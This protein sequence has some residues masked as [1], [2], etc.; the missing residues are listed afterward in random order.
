MSGIFLAV[1]RRSLVKP[2]LMILAF[3]GA[4]TVRMVWDQ[5]NPAFRTAQ[6][7]MLF[8]FGGTLIPI[9]AV[10]TMTDYW[11]EKKVATVIVITAGIAGF[12]VLYLRLSGSAAATELTELTGRLML[13]NLNPISMGQ[14]GVSMILAGPFLWR[15]ASL[16]VKAGLVGL[17]GLGAWLMVAANSRSPFLSLLAAFLVYLFAT[18][19]WRMLFILIVAAAA[20]FL[21]GHVMDQL[22]GSRLATIE[23]SSAMERYYVQNAAWS[24]FLEHPFLGAGYLD[25][26][27]G[28]Y[29]HNAMLESFMAL[30]FVGGALF[31]TIII[32]AVFH[33]LGAIRRGD[34]LL[35]ML[36]WQHLVL[37]SV[38]GSLYAS[39]VL[40]ALMALMSARHATSERRTGRKQAV[41]YQETLAYSYGSS[42]A[43]RPPPADDS[44]ELAL[45]GPYDGSVAQDD[46][47]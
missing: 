12:L 8:Y 11:R 1:V 29:P 33:S 15:G 6:D 23:D 39:P 7:D 31:C 16:P 36:F 19:R 17:G 18:R 37:A 40:F 45:R 41:R 38:S 14:F 20:V 28:L 9:L 24:A 22:Q 3:L 34:I 5:Q 35:S 43:R 25:P 47:T 26:A 4:Y 21:G 42:R 10:I 46:R 13:E 32:R 30:G 44:P 2:D 27:T